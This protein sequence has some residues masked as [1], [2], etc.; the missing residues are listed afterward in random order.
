MI[1]DLPGQSSRTVTISTT[2]TSVGVGTLDAIVTTDDNDERPGNNQETLQLTVDPAVDLA[3]STPTAASVNLDQSTTVNANLENRST[4]DAT[5]VTLSISL[6][7]GLRANSASWS[8]GSCTVTD[9]QVDCQ[10]ANFA[11]LSNSALTLGMTGTLAGTR[12]YTVSLASTEA[13]AIPAN[14]SANGAVTVTDPNARSSGG[15]MGL[16]FLCLLGLAVFLTRRRSI[17]F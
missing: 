16:P 14:N 7:N 5:G 15:A 3:V 8:I 12:S 17:A 4:F 6:N 1:G 2:P 13:D 9:Q 10:T 11:S